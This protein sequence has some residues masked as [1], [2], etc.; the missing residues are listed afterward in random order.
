MR[1]T[2]T[3]LPCLAALSALPASACAGPSSAASPANVVEVEGSS[4]AFPL[5][6]PLAGAHKL[7]KRVRQAVPVLSWTSSEASGGGDVDVEQAPLEAEAVEEAEEEHERW[8]TPEERLQEEKEERE[9]WCAL[10]SAVSETG[11]VSGLFAELVKEDEGARDSAGQVVFQAEP[12]ER[13]VDIELEKALHHPPPPALVAPPAIPASAVYRVPPSS[14]SQPATLPL[15]LSAFY[16]SLRSRLPTLTLTLA[17]PSRLRRP[18]NSTASALPL[19][20][21]KAFPIGLP[22]PPKL[23]WSF[24]VRPSSAGVGVSSS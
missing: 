15:F 8:W 3:L 24:A 2:L 10:L 4:S 11:Q 21:L 19:P 6:L 5:P 7:V 22:L 20:S 9:M 14:T 12:L 18:L 23:G 16:S 17:L 13:K 1:P